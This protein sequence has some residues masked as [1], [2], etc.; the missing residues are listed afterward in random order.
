MIVKYDALGKVIY[1]KGIIKDWT[2]SRI[3]CR[4]VSEVNEY[5][6]GLE[7]RSKVDDSGN[8]IIT[9]R[10]MG[11]K[12]TTRIRWLYNKDKYIPKKGESS[13]R[14]KKG[15]FKG[16]SISADVETKGFE[17]IRREIQIVDR[18]QHW[19]NEFNVGSM[20]DHKVL[21]RQ[22]EQIPSEYGKFIDYFRPIL[23]NIFRVKKLEIEL[24]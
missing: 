3:V 6:E 22:Q 13:K 23:E 4:D 10:K 15:K 18:D 21:R 5:L 19:I 17:T 8:Q 24:E 9:Y 1:E 11:A 2:A 16:M 14:E 12:K 7:P 20:E